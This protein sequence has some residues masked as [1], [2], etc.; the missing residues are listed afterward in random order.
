MF[1]VKK[2]HL[3]IDGVQTRDLS[4]RWGFKQR[5]GFQVRVGNTKGRLSNWGVELL[6]GF[7]DGC[8]FSKSCSNLG[9]K[10]RLGF[11]VCVRDSN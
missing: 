9:L 10:P 1:Q 8:G 4:Q 3:A 11:Q 6:M 5:I 7:Q 2:L